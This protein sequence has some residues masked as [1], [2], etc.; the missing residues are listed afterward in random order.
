MKLF[1]LNLFFAFISFAAANYCFKTYTFQES[2]SSRCRHRL[3]NRDLENVEDCCLLSGV[4]G[5]ATNRKGFRCVACQSKPTSSSADWSV[6]SDW[7]PCSATCG[8]GTQLRFRVCESGTC[9][10]NAVD[11][12]QCAD[13]NAC[14]VA[15][16]GG[17]TRWKKW[18]KCSVTCGKG[19]QYRLRSCSNPAP[20]NG[21]RPCVGLDQI[22]R[23]CTV[24]KKCV[25]HGGWSSWSG[26]SECDRSCGANALKLR[27]RLCNNPVP[28][29]GGND[30]QGDDVDIV[31]C[32]DVGPCP[33]DGSW[34]TWSAWSE[35]SV[36]CENGV[37]IRTRQCNDPSPQNGGK[38]CVGEERQTKECI[39]NGKCPVHGGL[40]EWGAWSICGAERCGGSGHRYRHRHCTNPVPEYGGKL[41]SEVQH[42]MESC[43]KECSAPTDPSPKKKCRSKAKPDTTKKV[44]PSSESSSHG[45]LSFPSME[46]P[47]VSIPIVN[48]NL[49]GI[50]PLSRTAR[51][52]VA[53]DPGFRADPRLPDGFRGSEGESESNVSSLDKI[54]IEAIIL[55]KEQPVVVDREIDDDS[56]SISVSSNASPFRESDRNEI[57]GTVQVNDDLEED[58]EVEP[59]FSSSDSGWEDCEEETS[60]VELP[61][62]SIESELSSSLDVQNQNIEWSSSSNQ[63]NVNNKDSEETNDA[64]VSKPLADDP[65]ISD[66]EK[67]SFSSS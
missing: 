57:D 17:W 52:V 50:H 37:V 3:P 11:I 2:G 28:A 58:S 5:F 39:M 49:L 43:I 53:P 29:E 51:Q 31:P 45:S 42:I 35:C 23:S 27:T 16:D 67:S 7:R 25:V 6:W 10:G 33:V 46:D 47:D 48:V 56:V 55:G 65:Q 60:N 9:S 19:T 34:N 41:C 26:F 22:E 62:V 44:F 63:H 24:Q 18:S 66:D 64:M 30:C 14:P 61:S 54:E 4:E 12:R 40:T 1:N 59:S 36:T 32:T 20:S 21:G 8:G 13:Q 15:V 38:Y